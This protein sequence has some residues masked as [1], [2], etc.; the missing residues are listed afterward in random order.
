MEPGYSAP[1]QTS[2]TAS[3]EFLKSLGFDVVHYTKTTGEENILKG[4]EKVKSYKDA[5]VTPDANNQYPANSHWIDGCVVKI[6]D[7]RLRDRIGETGKYP[8]WAIAFKYP[9]EEKVTTVSD[10]I[11]QTGRTGR[12]TP[13]AVF[14]PPLSLAG[15]TVSRATLHNPQIIQ[16]LKVDIG[17]KVLV[18][19]A[20]EIIPEVIRV[21]E[22]DPKMGFKPYYNIFSQP[23]PSCGGELV[24]G[25]DGTGCYCLNPNCHAQFS[26]HVEFWASR[27]C[28]D[29]SNFGP[30]QIQT[31]IEKGWLKSIPD[32][33]K[34]Y[35]HYD[36]IVKLEGF[37]KKSADKLIESINK[38]KEQ[39]IDRLIKALGI[40]N[41]GRT[42]GKALAAKYETLWDISKL[43]EETLEDIEGIGDISAEAIVSYF[44]DMS[45]LNALMELQELGVNMRS[46]KFGK[47]TGGNLVGLTF[48][49]TGTL[50]TMSR[51]QA[52]A[53]IEAHGGKVSGSVSKKTSYLVAGEAAGSKLQ[54]AQSLGVPVLSEAALKTLAGD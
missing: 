13:V 29:I 26:R 46:L 4:I 15:T 17:D 7:L 36:E 14:D 32:I 48:V 49:V 54:K 11:L 6:D 52:H 28:M 33:Y 16:D 53:Y 5:L 27:A 35:Q 10:I 51:D 45:N 34:L 30:S 19:K 37:G 38:S 2:H 18:R 47:A 12:V 23:C 41:V 31:F 22:P 20:A 42:I 24:S 44:S 1:Y 40:P 21:V 3:L 43:N 50:P 25:E 39:D 9:P 8:K